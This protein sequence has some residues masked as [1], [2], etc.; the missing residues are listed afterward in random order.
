MN[1]SR[2]A[3]LG[4]LVFALLSL[5]VAPPLCAQVGPVS[6]FSTLGPVVRI[7]SPANHATFD[8][9][10]DLP[11]FAFAH[12]GVD[13]LAVYDSVEFYASNSLGTKI[14]LGTGGRLSE[15]PPVFE[16]YAWLGLAGG[17]RLGS[18]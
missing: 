17:S 18:L 5:A 1:L 15:T 6:L 9:P 11:I 10:V 2:T 12:D 3:I 7:T 16:P 14:D 13:A 8:T 4:G